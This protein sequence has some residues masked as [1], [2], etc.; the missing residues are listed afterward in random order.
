MAPGWHADLKTIVR[1]RTLH[2]DRAVP[3]KTVRNLLAAVAGDF[4]CRT[5]AHGIEWDHTA[6]HM[7]FASRTDDAARIDALAGSL[8]R[9]RDETQSVITRD[10]VFAR[11]GDPG[12]FFFAV[13]AWGY[14]L[15]GYGPRRAREILEAAGATGVAAVGGTI[16]GLRRC[17]D[18]KAVLDA[19]PAGGAAK[20]YGVGAAFGTKF[21]YFDCYDRTAGRGP[22]IADR[23]SAWGLWVI[24]GSWDIRRSASLYSHYIHAAAAWADDLG[25]R[26]DDI[27]RALFVIGPYVEPLYRE[28]RRS[29]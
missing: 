12:E 19:L 17:A 11:R 29:S 3:R 21:A 13:M 28:I 4:T 6:W 7:T 10:Q 24:D 1:A 14:G 2:E 20:L 5:D 8:P 18:M 27:E 26:S 15:A 25:R 16:T 23:R 9:G 22:L